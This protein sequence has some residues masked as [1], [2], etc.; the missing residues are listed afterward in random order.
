MFLERPHEN[1]AATINRGL[2]S[3]PVARLGRSLALP[4]EQPTQERENNA[5]DNA[6]DDRK[7]EREISLPHC[8]VAR[9][10]A[11]P[12][13]KTGE[14][15]KDHPDDDEKT[16]KNHDEFPDLLH[17]DCLESLLH[18]AS[19]GNRSSGV[20]GVQE[21]QKAMPTATNADPDWFYRCRGHHLHRM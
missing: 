18:R 9:E 4:P 5:D 6:G 16:P 21:L 12:G 15:P 1:G 17:L 14:P 7:V 11:H 2:R 20:A 13:E 19:Q 10:F 3:T 8:D